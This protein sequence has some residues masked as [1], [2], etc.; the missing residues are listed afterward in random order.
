M[1]LCQQCGRDSLMVPFCQQCRLELLAKLQVEALMCKKCNL[2]PPLNKKSD[3][4][5]NCQNLCEY[6]HRGLPNLANPQ[7]KG[8]GKRMCNK[9]DDLYPKTRCLGC[10]EWHRKPNGLCDACRVVI[11]DLSTVNKSNFLFLING[12]LTCYGA[13]SRQISGNEVVCECRHRNDF[14]AYIQSLND[15]ANGPDEP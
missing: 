7:V 4:C 15:A 9:C 2:Y 10:Q 3:I 8:F 13:C 5:G 11:P 1:S 12:L 14:S 6:C